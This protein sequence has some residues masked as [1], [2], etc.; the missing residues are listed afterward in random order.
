MFDVSTI[1]E[2]HVMLIQE[3]VPLYQLNE[4]FNQGRYKYQIY[5]VKTQTDVF[6]V[7]FQIPFISCV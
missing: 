3:V 2:G 7:I 4:N 5:C 6:I 1:V